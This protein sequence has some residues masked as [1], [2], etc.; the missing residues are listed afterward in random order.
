MTWRYN[1]RIA[2][3]E[4]TE[5][6]WRA[7]VTRLSNEGGWYAYIERIAAPHDRRD[8]PTCAWSLE[9]RAWCEAEIKQLQ[10]DQR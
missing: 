3:W 8:G 7:V 10:L 4:A 2:N 9:G 6:G 1:A 5:G